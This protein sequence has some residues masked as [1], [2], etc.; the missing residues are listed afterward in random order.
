[1][2]F[3]REAFNLD[4]KKTPTR[5][6]IKPNVLAAR[7]T[8]LSQIGRTEDDGVTRF[9][10]TE[11]EKQAKALIKKWA[12]KAGL[13]LRE[14]AAGNIIGRVEG[15]D[16]TLP[17]VATG[18]H[19]D[20]VKNGGAF[21]GAL[22][23]LASLQAIESIIEEGHSHKRALEWLVFVNEEGS[24]FP[25]GIF[26]SQT[27]MGEVDPSSLE[28]FVDDDGVNLAEGMKASGLDPLQIKDA[29][30]DP[31]E[32]HAFLELHIEQGTELEETGTQIGVIKG[33]A[34]PVWLFCAFTGASDHA[35]NTP[36]GKRRDAGAAAAALTLATE[37][38]PE[39]F[40]DTAVAT[41]GTHAL[42]PNSTNV[43]PGK[44]ELTID[45]RDI[46]KASRD[47]LVAAIIQEGEA[48]ATQRNLSFSHQELTSIDP[49]PVAPAMQQ[50]L[51]DTAEAC[52]YSSQSLVS[53]AGHD[54][55]IIGRYVEKTAMLFVQSV[56]GIS[57]SPEE[58]TSVED[59]VAGTA[60]LKEALLRLANE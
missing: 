17:A 40:S 34:G 4:A 44:A 41:V 21:D 46:Q 26:G 32:L 28:R 31:A 42:T 35:G 11:E 6:G 22:G 49:V 51:T 5:Q 19:I 2:S 3:K 59:C 38:L 55:M 10:Y 43:V 33:I 15:S 36:M 8:A 18:S 27:M 9:V 13:T 53:G 48:I 1:M 54:A 45:I 23:V 25:T 37:E 60:V 20:S 12:E 39:R 24:R 30:R 56:K 57:H 50:L 52:G 29:K 47:A 58:F 7:L 14:D 16:P